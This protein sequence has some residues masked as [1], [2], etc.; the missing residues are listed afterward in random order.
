MHDPVR[1]LAQEWLVR[2]ERAHND[3][4]R[5]SLPGRSSFS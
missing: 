5:N 4:M 3:S 2:A 1:E